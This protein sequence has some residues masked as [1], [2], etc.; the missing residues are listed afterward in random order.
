[1]NWKQYEQ[2][3]VAWWNIK[4]PKEPAVLSP[5]NEDNT[6]GGID[7]IIKS[8]EGTKLAQCKHYWGDKKVTVHTVK[9]LYADMQHNHAKKGIIFTSGRF[10]TPAKEYA[11][12][13]NIWIEKLDDPDFKK[14]SKNKRA[15]S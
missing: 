6:D 15:Y 11:I 8:P 10:T 7:I 9:E 13:S 4:H 1:M 14:F 12:K 3:C 2:F 5:R